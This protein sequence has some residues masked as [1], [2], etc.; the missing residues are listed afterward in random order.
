M[1]LQSISVV[2]EF[3]RPAWPGRRS[4]S[5]D[6]TTRLDEGGRRIVGRPR[7]VRTRHSM[8]D[9]IC[10]LKDNAIV[11]V[12]PFLSSVPSRFPHL[13]E[14]PRWRQNLDSDL[15]IEDAARGIKAREAREGADAPGDR[16]LQGAGD[17]MSPGQVDQRSLRSR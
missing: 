1:D 9:N 4:L 13:V 17:E 3:M 16:G 14:P 11:P 10:G 5:D 7:E 6:R 2:L 12:P 15:G 8:A